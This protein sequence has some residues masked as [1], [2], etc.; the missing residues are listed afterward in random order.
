MRTTSATGTT[1]SPWTTSAGM[2]W[3]C[4]ERFTLW[5]M[6]YK[7]QADR[8]EEMFTGCF[9]ISKMFVNKSGNNKA[10]QCPIVHVSMP[11]GLLK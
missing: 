7:T 3:S 5:R 2:P 10:I 9:V 11:Q 4:P 8:N 1:P 6:R